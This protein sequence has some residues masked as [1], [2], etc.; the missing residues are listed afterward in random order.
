METFDLTERVDVVAK[1]ADFDDWDGLLALLR[2]AFATM[3][4]RID[5]PLS[6]HGFD[7][8]KLVAK[9]E[10]EELVLAFADGTL[11]GC[12]FAVRAATR[13]I[14]ARSPCARAC[15]AAVLPGACLPRPR[16]ARI[17]AAS[18]L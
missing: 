6:L 4:G 11:A 1:P 8:A 7:A 5:P 14:S 9:A 16:Q 13:S 10:E 17:R 15:G 18:Q 3:G 2:D 12:L